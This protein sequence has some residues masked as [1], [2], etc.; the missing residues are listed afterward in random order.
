MP[1]PIAPLPSVLL[2]VLLPTATYGLLVACFLRPQVT[3]KTGLEALAR[4]LVLAHLTIFAFV[5]LST[6]MLSA[7]DAVA[8]APVQAAW[9]ALLLTS[10]VLA[11]R[12]RSWQRLGRAEPRQARSDTTPWTSTLAIVVLL[13]LAITL[14]TALLYPPNTWDSM[15]YHMARVAHWEANQSIDFYPTSITRQNIQMPLAE[16]AILHLQI[17]TGSDRYANLVQWLSFLVLV[18]LAILIAAELGLDKPQQ[19]LSAV[20][21]A[22]LPMAILQASSTQNDLVVASFVM[23]FAWLLLRLQR[24]F[25]TRVLLLAGCAQ[26]LALLTKGTAYLYCAAIGSVLAAPILWQQ[27]ADARR[28]LE[29]AASLGGMVVL[30]LAM[31][32]GHLSRNHQLDGHPL[33][34]ESAHYRNQDVSATA[35]LGN[36]VR[37]CAVHLATPSAAA[38]AHLKRAAET[39]LCGVL[40]ADPNDPRTTWRG[41]RF[42]IRFT[43]HESRA[44]NPL[45]MLVAL[46][47][48]VAL[49][50]LAQPRDRRTVACYALG[51][52]LAAVLFC[53]VLKWQPWAPRLHLPLF[54][55]AAP[56]LAMVLAP[57]SLG[58]KP[59][60]WWTLSWWTLFWW[61]LAGRGVVALM[62][63]YST[64]FVLA[65]ESRSL[66]SR[67]WYT[68]TRA[69]RTFTIRKD[70]RPI[71]QE[72]IATVRQAEA[73]D[74]GLYFRYDDWEYP[75]WML[76]RQPNEGDQPIRFRHVGVRNRSRSLGD[77]RPLPP[78]VIASKRLD[79]WQHAA[80]YERVF[81]AHGISLFRRVEPAREPS[82]KVDT[83]VVQ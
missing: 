13:I 23:A 49:P 28:L 71:Y 25:R 66:L 9:T 4:A 32:A 58:R 70:L 20:I 60:F 67:D 79:T 54:A 7:V 57:R 34:G 2:S 69:E 1:E 82:T 77:D 6:E 12:R 17:L 11:W 27:R 10:F 81:A 62:I 21:V 80:R 8:H 74:I 33:G 31:N 16:F 37:H 83:G 35:R 22:T 72:I 61:K 48:L 36:I 39:I 75:L 73:H 56:L 47:G 53:W 29:T 3:Q 45:H 51:T 24:S 26:G 55:L 30:A 19:R 50:V 15:S 68:Q 5:A 46:L 18:G 42:D 59:G 38:N 41:S 52:T 65:N 76:A 63:A 64:I 43:R 40:G 14:V 44:G 78:F